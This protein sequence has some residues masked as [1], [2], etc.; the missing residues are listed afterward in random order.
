MGREG[1]SI[2]GQ[3]R[4]DELLS[5]KP[6]DRRTI[7]EEA[8]GI[9]KFKSRKLESER[10]LVR[11]R[12]NMSRVNDILRE[13]ER[14]LEPLMKQAETAKK[15]LEFH[16]QLR[17]NEIN[18]YIYQR[19]TANH[20]KFVIGER[21]KGVIDEIALRQQE[22]DQLIKDY[23]SIMESRETVDKDIESLRDKLV[24]LTVGIADK[25]GEIKLLNQQLSHLKENN[26]TLSD[27]N[28][29]LIALKKENENVLVNKKVELADL[30][31]QLRQ[32]E[33]DRANKNDEF[34]QLPTN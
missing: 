2:I 18:A 15:Y 23:R 16:E 8:A 5:S 9:S 4:I 34:W 29:G 7:F 30:Q 27:E 28:M 12:D 31:V 1:Y 10:K 20:S 25:A 33:I 6:E 17:F 3:G 14:Q 13:K 26:Q 32:A 24:V 21:L 11:T 22:N 19:E